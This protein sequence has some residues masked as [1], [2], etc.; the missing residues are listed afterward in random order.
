VSIEIAE[1]SKAPTVQQ[2]DNGPQTTPENE[3]FHCSWEWHIAR[4]SPVC[5][6][7]Y[8]LAFKVSGGM[9]RKLSDRRF[10]SS[11]KA[12]AS[13]FGYSESHIRRGLRELEEVGFFQLIAKKKFK[14]THYRVLSHDD[15]A[16][17]HKGKCTTKV[18][19][20]W[21]GEGDSL[22]QSLWKISGGQVKF[23]GFQ[24]K[25]LRNLGVD[26]NK[27][28]EEFSG[29]W[30]QTGQRMSPLNVPCGFYMNV[31]DSSPATQQCSTLQ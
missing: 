29:Y 7:I 15:W 20:P 4:L 23:A 30:E 14:P 3:Y 24:V 1:K 12:L 19:Y 10:F 31:K 6:L 11:A 5:A 22:G 26:E 9:G 17:K 28:V 8:P 21:T 27:I 13:Y 16:S 18:E 25:N 2:M